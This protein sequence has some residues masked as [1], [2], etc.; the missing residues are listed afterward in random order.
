MQPISSMFKSERVRERE[1]RWY[2]TFHSSTTWSG[3]WMVF[4]IGGYLCARTSVSMTSGDRVLLSVVYH[5]GDGG[6]LNNKLFV[7]VFFFFFL[8][9]YFVSHLFSFFLNY[10]TECSLI[11]TFHCNNKII[12]SSS[13]SLQFFVFRQ[14]ML[15]LFFHP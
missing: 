3:W 12:I 10:G 14:N 7:C 13:L 4:Y 2:T 15:F 11:C 6:Y 8:L 5:Q 1:K 9:I